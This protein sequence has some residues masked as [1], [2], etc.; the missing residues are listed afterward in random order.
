M[1]IPSSIKN[2]LLYK[3][4]LIWIIWRFFLQVVVVLAPI[5]IE[6]LPSFPYYEIL[7]STYL[8]KSIYSWANFDGVHYLT[9]VQFGYRQLDL[10]Q[11]F[12]PVYPFLVK[13]ISLLINDP[14][15]SGLL[16]SSVSS[17][18]CIYFGFKVSKRLFDKKTAIH[19]IAVLLSFPTSFYLNAVYNESLFLL[20]ILAGVWYSQTN[21][22]LI[23]GLLM[24]LSSGV[25]LVGLML[26]P[27]FFLKWIAS[28]LNCSASFKLS[29]KAKFKN[30][31]KFVIGLSI[32]SIALILFMIL[33]KQEFN[34]PFYFFSV[35][36]DFGTGR[37]TNLVFPLQ[38]FY[39]SIKMLIFVRPI[40]VKYFS[41]AQDF[42]ISTLVFLGILFSWK[43]IKLEYS[44]FSLISYTIPI[45]T[46]NLSSM[47][48][49]VLVLF[50]VMMW[51][52][53]YISK[54][55]KLYYAYYFVSTLLL[56]INLTLFIQGYW[57]A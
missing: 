39:R 3:A 10:I 22:K 57:V 56:I 20:L 23:S 54:R 40:D 8:P 14:L 51:W 50:P 17:I 9:I 48:R 34:N 11:A 28:S 27:S 42:V 31:W 33:L 36:A 41:Y 46:G 29:L 16:L 45:L 43:K 15:V 24:G 25:R 52:A 55:K 32:G 26:I 4:F 37:Q 7:E 38:S 12:F 44:L 35:Q 21:K 53:S 49:Y 6:Y 19:Y 47:P 1:K 2:S 5:F 18:G 13:M 30:N